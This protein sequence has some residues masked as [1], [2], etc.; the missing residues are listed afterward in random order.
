MAALTI[1]FP[2]TV[3]TV[4]FGGDEIVVAEVTMTG[5]TGGG[6]DGEHNDLDGR[7]TA[8]AH[9]IS[10]ITGLQA[11]LDAAGGGGGSSSWYV[12]ALT[13]QSRLTSILGA[14]DFDPGVSIT[15]GSAIEAGLRFL[16]YTDSSNTESYVS[17]GTTVV[18]FEDPQPVDSAVEVAPEFWF[19]PNVVVAAD[20][21]TNEAGDQA[22]FM[23]VVD[24]PGA[25]IPLRIGPSTGGGGGSGP[26]LSDAD[27]ADLGT[28]DSGASADASRADHVHDMP[29][30]ADV[31][32]VDV[33]LVGAPD[34]VA[35]L[36][37]GG[38]VPSSQLPSYVDDVIEAANFAALPG[39]GE[40]GKIYVTLDNNLT[41]RWA[42]SV[43]AEISASL[44]LGETSSTAH[45][46]DHGKTAHDHSQ[47]VTGNPHGTT[48]S[49]VGAAATSHAHSG[50]DITS[51][52]V[53]PSVLGTG[54]ANNTTFLRGDGTWTAP[55]SSLPGWFTDLAY[56]P[57]MGTAH[58][59]IGGGS[60]ATIAFGADTLIMW[61]IMA[62]ET[63]DIDGVTV[64]IQTAGG[65]GQQARFGI[66]SADVNG[67]PS[68]AAVVDSGA[69][70]VS[71]AVTLLTSTFTAVRLQ[72]YRPM[73]AAMLTSSA[74]VTFRFLAS[75]GANTTPG[76]MLDTGIFGT[77]G[78][79]IRRATGVTFGALPTAPSMPFS[80]I[81]NIIPGV[82][83]RTRR[84]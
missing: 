77:N 36:D 2:Q 58:C 68:G 8:D 26:D 73:W 55:A 75:A 65:A 6:F 9:P 80:N 53:A 64:M 7:S 47:V 18:P 74:A 70:S 62:V 71:S 17:D 67:V 72:P 63:V 50:T 19:L 59:Q 23:L 5:G 82:F 10:A 25:A 84:V 32:A 37:S 22:Q 24:G 21:Y 79:Q 45:R 83:W 44:A 3:W 27:P 38:L 42:G 13:T 16:V 76:Q 48:A 31:G 46:G 40:T 49:D 33:A 60:A 34:G 51:G 35:E 11:A 52:L 4:E 41:F 54:A 66:Y 69:M 61:R 12:Y 20:F 78:N 56:S 57:L 15:F 81:T 1:E 14:T 28:A 30:A 29:T 39:T 43:Y